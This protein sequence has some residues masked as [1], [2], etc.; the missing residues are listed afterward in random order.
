MEIVSNWEIRFNG[1]LD[2][3]WLQ[4]NHLELR[5]QFQRQKSFLFSPILSSC[6]PNIKTKVWNIFCIWAMLHLY[7]QWI[8]TYSTGMNAVQS[9]WNHPTPCSLRIYNIGKC[10]W[11]VK[12]K[13]GFIHYLDSGYSIDKTYTC[14]TEFVNLHP[15]VVFKKTDKYTRFIHI[16]T[17]LCIHTHTR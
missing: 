1:L 9:Q 3:L 2:C 10:L 11:G 5:R 6:Y 17:Y 14:Q 15:W 4:D 7:Q 16:Y 12:N 8:H 13:S